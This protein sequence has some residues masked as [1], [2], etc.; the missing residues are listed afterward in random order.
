MFAIRE[1]SGQVYVHEYA[2]RPTDAAAS[3]R[4][5]LE[6]VV[7]ERPSSATVLGVRPLSDVA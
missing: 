4:E 7:V 2:T 5:L 3:M 1:L 6:P